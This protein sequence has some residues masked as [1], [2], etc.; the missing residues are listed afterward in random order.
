MQDLA[1]PPKTDISVVLCEN[2][3]DLRRYPVDQLARDIIGTPVP[4]TFP[5]YLFFYQ[6]Q[7]RGWANVRR[8]LIVYPCLHPD[9]IEPR[10]FLKLVKSLVTE[11]KRHAGD[12]IFLL[13][14]YARKLGPKNMRRI[15]LKKMDED[16]YEYDPEA[17]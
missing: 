2:E 4:R 3:R 12:P 13:C 1:D 14:D 8:Q 10:V 15:R 17:P 5:I 11:F 7:L 9:K 6:G 16:A